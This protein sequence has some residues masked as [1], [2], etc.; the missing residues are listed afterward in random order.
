MMYLKG[1]RVSPASSPA[2]SLRLM[3]SMVCQIFGLRLEAS[4]NA[5]TVNAA[6]ALDLGDTVEL[7]ELRKDVDMVIWDV[8]VPEGLAWR[9]ATRFRPKEWQICRGSSS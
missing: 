2:I 7:F 6:K 3:L 1:K 8:D 4:L 9:E 5:V